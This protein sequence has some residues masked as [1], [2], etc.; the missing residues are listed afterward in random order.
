MMPIPN[1]FYRIIHW[2]SLYSKTVLNAQ[3]E[4]GD[5]ATRTLDK[6]YQ[7]NNEATMITLRTCTIRRNVAVIREKITI[8]FFSFLGKP[9]HDGRQL[10]INF[11][12][13]MPPLHA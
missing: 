5:R 4:E 12:M 2:S 8:L 6:V 1:Y 13:S 9:E 3:E 7:Q 11:I 10:P